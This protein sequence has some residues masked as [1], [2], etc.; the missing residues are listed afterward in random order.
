MCFQADFPTAVGVISGGDEMVEVDDLSN[1]CD[2]KA[3]KKY[4]F[5]TVN[6]KVPRKN[7]EMTT[8]L[9]DGMGKNALHKNKQYLVEC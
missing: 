5:D 6:I 2:T 4:Y 7:M 9:R 3:E 8:C 1:S